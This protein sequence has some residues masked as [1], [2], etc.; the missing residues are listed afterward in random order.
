[1]TKVYNR[2][3]LNIQNS[4]L[5]STTVNNSIVSNIK[6]VKIS[7][8]KEMA[9]ISQNCKEMMF[10]SENMSNSV[11]EGKKNN[12][13]CIISPI[14]LTNL[15]L[16][17]KRSRDCSKENELLGRKQISFSFTK[18]Q[19]EMINNVNKPLTRRKSFLEEKN[20]LIQTEINTMGIVKVDYS[21][22]TR[23][24]EEEKKEIEKYQQHYKREL[25]EFLQ[26]SSK[27]RFM[28]KHF[29][30]NYNKIETFYANVK[31]TSDRR[32]M[33]E[34]YKVKMVKKERNS[35]YLFR[36]CTKNIKKVWHPKCADTKQSNKIILNFFLLSEH[37]FI[38]NQ[39]ILAN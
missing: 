31:K 14:P 30:E 15:I 17:K 10:N 12:S 18:E 25:N 7:I 13:N 1:M 6:I 35:M 27:N 22:V 4:D 32:K 16:S 26:K 2:G 36:N 24:K 37:L 38:I 20:H 3:M 21:L 5:S 9:Q 28:M 11:K 8:K 23:K 34:H 29:P 19:L 33:K 39:E